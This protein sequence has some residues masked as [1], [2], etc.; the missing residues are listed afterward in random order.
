VRIQHET[1]YI[2]R[3]IVLAML[4]ISIPSPI[5]AEEVERAVPTEHVTALIS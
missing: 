3:S 1:A 4:E 2:E 5:L